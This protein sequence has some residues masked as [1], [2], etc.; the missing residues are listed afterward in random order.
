MTLRA[1]TRYSSSCLE[2]SFP[3]TRD[4]CSFF[5]LS[6]LLLNI[7]LDDNDCHDTKL[8]LDDVLAKLMLENNI[9]II[10]Q[11]LGN[12]KIVLCKN[13]LVNIFIY[14]RAASTASTESTSVTPGTVTTEATCHTSCI[15]LIFLVSFISC[16]Y[17]QYQ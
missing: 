17:M 8:P 15:R 11:E 3:V 4:L 2:P 6:L 12:F 1:S 7:P 16:N 14:V 9:N 13:I 5:F 10:H